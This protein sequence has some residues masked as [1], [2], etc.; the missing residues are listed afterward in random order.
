LKGLSGDLL[1]AWL[2]IEKA[3]ANQITKIQGY[4]AMLHSKVLL[5][6]E[7]GL[8]NKLYSIVTIPAIKL[9]DYQQQ[10]IMLLPP[11]LRPCTSTW[12]ITMGLPCIHRY[13]QAYKLKTSLTADEFHLQWHWNQ[14]PK[15]FRVQ[16]IKESIS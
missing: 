14:P 11:L 4:V 2:S 9:V 16:P 3:I 6:V 5:D 7:K 8:Y 10:E 12:T 1:T 15:Q 13:N